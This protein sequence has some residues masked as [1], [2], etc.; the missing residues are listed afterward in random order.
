MQSAIDNRAAIVATCRALRMWQHGKPI[1]VRN[2]AI[3]AIYIL[4]RMARGSGTPQAYAVLKEK[5]EKL[6]V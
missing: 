6:R 2:A 4:L 1:E 5:I 3:T